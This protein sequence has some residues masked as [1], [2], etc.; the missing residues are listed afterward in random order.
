MRPLK[1]FEEFIEQG[2]IRKS[3]PNKS[4]ARSLINESQKR[5]RFIDQAISKMGLSDDSA[6]VYIEGSYDALI[7]LIRARMLIKGFVSSGEGAHE[8]EV[9]YMRK[10]EFGERQVR[11]MNDLRYYRNGILYYGKEFNAEFAKK[12]LEFLKVIYPK[13]LSAFKQDT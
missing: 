6:N 3:S 1:S 8:A 5:K 7:E 9:S 12:V 2:T 11:F 4:R 10:M 13:L